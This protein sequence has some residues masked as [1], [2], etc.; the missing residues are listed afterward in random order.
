MA[1]GDGLLVRFRPIDGALDV[2][3]LTAIAQAAQRFGNGRIE[4][5][6]RGSVQLRGLAHDTSAACA[7]ALRDAVAIETGI[8]VETPPLAGLLPESQN[9]LDLAA[10]LRRALVAFAGRVPAKTTVVIDDGSLAGLGADI[11]IRPEAEGW[12]IDGAHFADEDAVVVP[13]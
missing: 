3:A 6:S 13:M 9:L 4:I 12:R 1:T 11:R 5:T 7:S 2:A 8:A 10:T